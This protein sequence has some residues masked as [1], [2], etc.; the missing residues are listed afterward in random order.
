M[1]YQQG[2]NQSY[3]KSAHYLTERMVLQDNPCRAQY[4]CY[5]NE[6]TQ[7]AHRVVSEQGTESNQPT[8][9]GTGSR[10]VFAELP[11]QVDNDTDNHHDKRGKDN[12]CHIPGDVQPVHHEQAEH[13]GSDG[14]DERHISPFPFR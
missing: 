11:F 10:H 1:K 6:Y 8:Y 13:I 14:Q 4:A 12:S 7:P 2:T 3:G 5:E 9:Y